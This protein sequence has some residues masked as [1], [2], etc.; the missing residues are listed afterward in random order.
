MS[1]KLRPMLELSAH[2]ITVA[3]TAG[4]KIHTVTLFNPTP[5]TLKKIQTLVTGM[6]FNGIE[7]IDKF[8]NGEDDSHSNPRVFEFRTIRPLDSL[9]QHTWQLMFQVW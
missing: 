5:K 1:F 3:S 7:L 9:K 4:D 8:D 6:T 2:S